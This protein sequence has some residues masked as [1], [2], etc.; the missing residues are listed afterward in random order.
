VLWGILAEDWKLQRVFER[1]AV[2]A[3]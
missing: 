2:A 3:S 1:P